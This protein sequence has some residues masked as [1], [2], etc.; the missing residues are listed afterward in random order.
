MLYELIESEVVYTGS[1]QVCSREKWT[2]DPN[3]EEALSIL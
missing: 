3:A 2:K 1:S